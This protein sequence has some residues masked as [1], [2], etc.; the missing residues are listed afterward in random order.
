MP[1]YKLKHIFKNTTATRV[2]T[3]LLMRPPSL[4]KS[5]EDPFSQFTDNKHSK[6]TSSNKKRKKPRGD[7]DLNEV[8]FYLEFWRQKFESHE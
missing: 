7:L 8:F 1:H 6:M 5:S 3:Y 4:I 2:N